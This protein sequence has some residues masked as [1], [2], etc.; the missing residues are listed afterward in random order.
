MSWLFASC[1][2]YEWVC[3]VYPVD[4]HF[5]C[6]VYVSVRRPGLLVSVLVTYLAFSFFHLNEILMIIININNQASV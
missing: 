4:H 6:V 3:V 5:S 2:L 1:L